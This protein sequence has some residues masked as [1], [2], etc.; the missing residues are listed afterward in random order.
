MALF[1]GVAQ[2]AE[3]NHEHIC[4]NPPIFPPSNPCGLCGSVTV[5]KVIRN[6]CGNIKSTWWEVECE[7]WGPSCA[8]H[9][10]NTLPKDDDGDLVPDIVE[11]LLC[12]SQAIYDLINTPGSPLQCMSNKDLQY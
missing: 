11:I 5:D 6:L 12:D 1:L 7:L 9:E 8:F 3:A 10:D 4:D 2:P